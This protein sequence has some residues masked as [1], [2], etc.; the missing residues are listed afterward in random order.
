MKVWQYGFNGLQHVPDI[1]FFHYALQQ[2][3]YKYILEKNYGI[4]VENM[5][6]IV[7]HPIFGNYQKFKIPDMAEEVAIIK[8]HIV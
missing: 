2:N 3:L 5:Y 7:L 4:I 8:S 1:K 6:I